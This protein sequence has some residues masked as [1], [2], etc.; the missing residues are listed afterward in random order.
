MITEKKYFGEY[1]RAIGNK[2]PGLIKSFDFSERVA[3]FDYLTQ[4][5]AV[6]SSNI[7]GNPLDLNSFMNHR[8]NG[9]AKAG[10]EV[11][12]IEDLIAAYHFAQENPP[13]EA[14]LLHAHATLSKTLLIKSNRGKYRVEPVGVFGNRGLVYLAVEPELVPQ[15]MKNFLAGIENLL[16]EPLA[17]AEIFYH[18]SLIHLRFAHIHPFRDGNGRAARL[19]EKWFVAAKLGKQFWQI[20]SEKFYWNHRPDYYRNLN[21]G[22]NFYTLNYDACM[23]FLIMLP[24]CLKQVFEAQDDANVVLPQ[25][26][27]E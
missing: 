1:A 8:L 23:E 3:T 13:C 2:I 4:A 21:L 25:N 5:S 27:Q 7:E 20:P 11:K 18:A 10:K 6:Y 24:N 14:N 15:E 26:K 16:A 22:P 17:P 19:L 12:E 9:K